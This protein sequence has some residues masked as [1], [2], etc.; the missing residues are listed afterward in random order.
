MSLDR[1]VAQA[2]AVLDAFMAALNGRNEAALNDT[3]NFPHVRIAG[4]KVAVFERR[5]DYTFEY[6]RNRVAADGWAHSAWDERTVIHS[7]PEKVHLAVVFS[8]FRADGSRIASFRSI[9]IVTCQDGHW[10][11][12]GRSSYAA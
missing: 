9:Y 6:F 1:N 11:I 8:R 4:G 3:L 2:M 5:G 7:G 10:G 12:Q